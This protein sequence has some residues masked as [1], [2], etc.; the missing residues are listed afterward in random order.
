MSAR[1]VGTLKRYEGRKRVMDFI[2]IFRNGK[3]QRIKKFP[4]DK[5][6]DYSAYILP[7]KI[8]DLAEEGIDKCSSCDSL[9]P[10]G[11]NFCDHCDEL[12]CCDCSDEHRYEISD[13][14]STGGCNY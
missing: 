8:D 3:L 6:K 7:R 9:F 5:T 1:T 14:L 12:F 4:D 13:E 11:L 10:D 2:A